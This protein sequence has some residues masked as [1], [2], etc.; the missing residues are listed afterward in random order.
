[1][2]IFTTINELQNWRKSLD[3]TTVV[4]FVPT[5]GYLHDGHISL[6][7]QAKKSTSTVVVSIFV[8]PLQFGANEDLSA[9]PRDFQR[10]SELCL[11][12]GVDAIFAPTAKEIY[13]NGYPPK[14]TINVAE[15]GKNLCG[16]KRIGHFDG[17]CTVVAKIFNLV[18]PHKAF[19]GRKDIQQLRIIETMTAELNFPIEI[20]G[21]DIVRSKEGLALSSRNSYLSPVEKADALI[22]PKLLDYISNLIINNQFNPEN[23]T[24]YAIEFLRHLPNVKL[25]YLEVVD[26][27]NLQPIKNITG[28]IVIATAVFIGK[29]R[30][31]DNIILSIN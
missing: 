23:L 21:C 9:Y 19:F 13:S 27:K 3:H 5:M 7:N 18:F 11:N 30:L 10:D 28:K 1:M 20:I 17:V 14:C 15:L 26:Y 12:A 31:I 6:I 2:Q 29:T 22:V 4:G 25:D 16:A 24:N 8:N